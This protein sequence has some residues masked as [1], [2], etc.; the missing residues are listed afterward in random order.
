VTTNDIKDMAFF[1]TIR[2]NFRHYFS[3]TAECS[4]ME[5]LII[6]LTNPQLALSKP[7]AALLATGKC[8]MP[9]YVA[10]F[11]YLSPQ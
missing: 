4:V 6:F 3:E 5:W 1:V 8:F 9:E 7:P 2:I 11:F 10:T